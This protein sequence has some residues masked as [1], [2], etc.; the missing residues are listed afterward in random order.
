MAIEIDPT[1]RLAAQRAL[2]RRVHDA[3]ASAGFRPVLCGAGA[4]TWRFDLE[5]PVAW[6]LRWQVEGDRDHARRLVEEL[7][8]DAGAAVSW[9]AIA[10]AGG[11]DVAGEP[12]G[13][14]TVGEGAAGDGRGIANFR[15]WALRVGPDGELVGLPAAEA[16][17]AA[18][19]LGGE[20]S[21]PNWLRGDGERLLELAALAAA[22]GLRPAPEVVQAMRRDALHVLGVDRARWAHWFG[23]LLTGTRPSV[24]LQLLFDAG[25]LSL[26]VPEVALLVDFH[27]SAPAAHK[28]IWDH[29]LQVVDK[30]PPDLVVRW[31]ALMH[32]VGKVWTRSAGKRGKVQFLRHEELGASLMEGVAGRF[33]LDADL[34]HRVCYV[35]GNHARAN[36]Y[37]TN[38]TDSAVRRLIRDM[39]EHLDAV[40]AFSRSDFTTKRAWRIREVRELGEELVRR[41]EEVRT[42]DAKPS[43]LPKGFGTLVLSRTGR[44]PGPWLGAIQRM[45]E[46][47]VEAGRLTP[48]T[49]A[50]ASWAWLL[51]HRPELLSEPVPAAAAIGRADAS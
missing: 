8:L 36:V 21:W 30:C 22:T 5:L 23:A 18:G 25:A 29:T 32:D 17:L 9:P 43:A 34:A 20:R 31:A 26:I 42:A 33:H 7:R 28:D 39:G 49:D 24:G 51:A 50:E 37:A 13:A 35:I 3:L 46:D 1:A 38:W 15:L 41:I 2:L 47:E 10:I 27:R 40:L 12:S 19:V 11:A 4:V 16:E 14:R 6:P 48:S 44:R 45:F